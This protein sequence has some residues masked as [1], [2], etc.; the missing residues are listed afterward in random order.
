MVLEVRK[1]WT[2]RFYHVILP[3][4]P[5]L[6]VALRISGKLVSE[7]CAFS[8]VLLSQ[9]GRP[10]LLPLG[11]IFSCSEEAAETPWI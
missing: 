9:R 6:A 1:F 11:L 4:D 3:I 2:E 10:E 8:Q 7:I 5:L